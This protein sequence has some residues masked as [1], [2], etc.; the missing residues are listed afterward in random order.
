MNQPQRV[1]LDWRRPALIAAVEYL[2]RKYVSGAAVTAAYSETASVAPAARTGGSK[3]AVAGQRSLSFAEPSGDGEPPAPN[4]SAGSTWDLSRV[5]VVVP[6]RRAGRRLLELL[7]FEAR[8]RKLHFIPPTIITEGGLPELLYS[9]KRPFADSLTQDLAWSHALRKLSPQ[10]LRAI[11]PHPPTDDD[12]KGWLQLGNMLRVRHTELAAD[13][14]TFNDVVQH[15]QTLPTFP[16]AARWQAMHTVQDLFL[17]TLDDLHL[18]DIQTARLKAIEFQEIATDFE[19]VLLGTVDLNR[20]LRTMLDLVAERVTALIAAPEALADRFDSHGCV[21]PEQWRQVE[22]PLRDEQVL[23]V[24]G[25]ADQ[26]DATAK[27]LSGFGG[28]YRGDQITVGVAD[29]RLV[30]HLQRQLEQCAVPVRWVEGKRLPDTGPYRLLAALAELLQSGTLRDFAALVRHPDVFIC[31]TARGMAAAEGDGEQRVAITLLDEVDRLQADYLV[32]RLNPQHWPIE[33][34]NKIAAK[35]DDK[36]RDFTNVAQAI[37]HVA[38]L[39]APLRANPQRLANWSGPILAILQTM[40]E[41]HATDAH[42]VAALEKIRDTLQ[43]QTAL[44]AELDP[45]LTAAEAITWTLDQLGGEAIPPPADDEAIELLGWL[46]LPLDDAPALIVTTFNEGFTPESTSGDSF[47]PN[48]IRKSLGLLDNDRRYARD[49]YAV[50]AILASRETVHFISARRDADANPLV[51]SRLLFATA[52][53][54]V[55]ARARK[56]F[57][58]LSEVQPRAPLVGAGLPPPKQSR[59]CV[60]RPAANVDLPTRLKVTQFRDY[61][62]CPYRFYLKQLLKLKGIDDTCEE[63]AANAFGNLLHKVL[64]RFGADKAVRDSVDDKDIFE[65]LNE[66]LRLALGQRYGDR[67]RLAAVEIQV[68]QMR[69]RLQRFAA[70]QAGH[71]SEGWRIVYSETTDDKATGEEAPAEKIE[72]DVELLVDDQAFF[73]G[74][75]IDRIDQHEDHETFRIFDYKT[76]DRADPPERVHRQRRNGAR[77]WVDLQLPLYRHLAK[78]WGFAGVMQLGYI[79]IPKSLENVGHQLAEWDEADL[80]SADDTMRDVVRRIRSREFWPPQDSQWI[81]DL[82]ALCQDRRLGG[83]LLAEIALEGNLT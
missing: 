44:P 29:E 12:A 62:A 74:G 1:F 43:A 23:R 28:K 33:V 16:D 5:I 47:L 34:R 67:D 53:E 73:L 7:V 60:P 54:K 24:D 55:V 77:Q 65:F 69:S 6:G 8:E 20:T 10:Q 40:Y 82:T 22:I 79:V 63:L 38:S 58:P 78:A 32:T 13:R 30:P 11:V 35:D 41:G 3:K 31:L 18:W 39:L 76:G 26:A 70:W 72:K 21:Q 71:R 45:S 27:I 68:E 75:R 66:Q 80:T 59:L 17:R 42:T 14:L 57:Q 51:P 49:A 46:E 48:S 15:G 4:D 52:R 37:E 81:D 25:P 9:P 2:R 36:K 19:I 83:R 64:E 56:F 61:L 50:S